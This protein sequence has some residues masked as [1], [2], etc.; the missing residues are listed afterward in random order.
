MVA[1][2]TSHPTARKDHKCSDCGRTIRPG[3]TYRRGV[4]FECGEFDMC[5]DH[6]FPGP[7]REVPTLTE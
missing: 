5:P 4:G 7:I 2:M 1:W 3:E 6:V